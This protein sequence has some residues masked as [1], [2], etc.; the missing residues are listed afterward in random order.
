LGQKTLFYTDW[1]HY[2]ANEKLY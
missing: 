1:S 2:K